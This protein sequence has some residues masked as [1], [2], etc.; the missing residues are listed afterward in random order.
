MRDIITSDD[1]VSN[2][3]NPKVKEIL[4]KLGKFDYSAHVPT[5][6]AGIQILTT[7]PSK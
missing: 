4:K 5:G 6:V 7:N 3:D 1:L 2:Y